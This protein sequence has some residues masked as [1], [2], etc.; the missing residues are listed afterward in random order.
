M[1]EDGGKFDGV[2]TAVLEREGR[3]EMRVVLAVCSDVDGFEVG[4]EELDVSR[5][6]ESGKSWGGGVGVGVEGRDGEERLEGRLGLR[7]EEEQKRRTR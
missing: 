5:E 2:G 6:D 3:E 7:E 1:S 4:D